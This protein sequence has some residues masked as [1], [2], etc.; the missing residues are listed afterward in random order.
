MNLDMKK[1]IFIFFLF[2]LTAPALFAQ[3]Y[4]Q[5]QV[6]Q[7][8]NNVAANMRTMTCNFVQ[9]KTLHMLKSKV[10]SRG[11]MYYSRANRLR[12]EYTSPY[13]YT[14]ILNGQTVWLKNSRGNSRINVEQSKMFKEITRIMMSSVLGTCVSNNR[15][16]N[17]SLQ[18]HGNSWHAVMRP[19]R[20][21]MKQMFST[22][23]VYFDMARSMV[24]SVRMVER[25]GDTT[26]IQLRNVR[27]NTPVNAKVFSLN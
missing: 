5:A 27:T 24:S 2:L 21:P 14:F 18:G 15:D 6:R 12:W 13:H 17:V 10:T 7:R 22:I 4:S 23:T 3:N 11:N 8:I 25:N 9:T 1:Q 19:K 20:N 16:F 26:V